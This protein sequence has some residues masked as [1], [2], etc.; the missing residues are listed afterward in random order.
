MH[1]RDHWIAAAMLVNLLEAEAPDHA[2]NRIVALTNAGDKAGAAAWG[3]I[4]A[5]IITLR[6]GKA[7]EGDGRA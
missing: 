7:K 4:L 2:Q 1:P 3:D 6:L 5:A